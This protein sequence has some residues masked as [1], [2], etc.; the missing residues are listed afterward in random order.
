[1]AFRLKNYGG[2]NLKSRDSDIKSKNDKGIL[3]TTLSKFQT[4]FLKFNKLLR[5]AIVIPIIWTISVLLYIFFFNPFGYSIDSREW[6]MLRGLILFPSILIVL[7][8]LAYTKLIAK[9]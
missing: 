6:D 1:M 9:K 3:K 8:Y 2:T 7:C 4:N 5:I